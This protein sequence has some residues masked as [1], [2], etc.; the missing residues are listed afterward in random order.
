[1]P[2]PVTRNVTGSA[3]LVLPGE[4]RQKGSLPLPAVCD[5]CWK[6]T[7]RKIG[8]YGRILGWNRFCTDSPCAKAFAKS[9]AW[10][11]RR[12]PKPAGDVRKPL[13]GGV[14]FALLAA[15]A[16]DDLAVAA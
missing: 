11:N 5:Y 14:N 6:P 12:F 1:M 8:A 4:A 3:I 9:G 7:D 15:G 2:Q 16:S 13:R 10:S